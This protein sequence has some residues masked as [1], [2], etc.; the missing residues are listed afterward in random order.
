M[1]DAKLEWYLTTLVGT[2]L[3]PTA[4]P[5]VLDA[6][7]RIDRAGPMSV[8]QPLQLLALRRYLRIK[9]GSIGIWQQ[10]GV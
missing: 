7:E 5:L 9:I 8:A 4:A 1:R 2:Q 6:L 10:S 3:R